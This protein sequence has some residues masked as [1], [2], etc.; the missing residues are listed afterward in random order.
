MPQMKG[1]IRPVIA[2]ALGYHRGVGKSGRTFT[3]DALRDQLLVLGRPTYHSSNL[4]ALQSEQLYQ[5]VA[6]VQQVL[7]AAVEVPP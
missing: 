5:A 4:V 6:V 7:Q 2:S 3:K 1:E